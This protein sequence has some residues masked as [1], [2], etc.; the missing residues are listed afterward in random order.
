MALY[1]DWARIDDEE[2]ELQ[3]T[4]VRTTSNPAHL[5]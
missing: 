2:E 1:D 4:S 3:D 5:A